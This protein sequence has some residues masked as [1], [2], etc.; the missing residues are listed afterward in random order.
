MMNVFMF[1]FEYFYEL[2]S[3][4]GVYLNC[5]IFYL[6]LYI[7]VMVCILSRWMFLYV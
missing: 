6:K 3:G 2:K 4:F 1:L 7:N 5:F